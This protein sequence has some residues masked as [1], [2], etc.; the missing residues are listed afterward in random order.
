[1]KGPFEWR[2]FETKEEALTFIDNNKYRYEHKLIDLTFILHTNPNTKYLYGV[3]SN[4]KIIIPQWE[5][6]VFGTPQ[7]AFNFIKNNADRFVFYKTYPTDDG[8]NSWFVFTK[9]KRRI[10]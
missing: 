4:K 6:H 1:M 3:M 8:S 9:Q 2:E 5:T 7:E 10:N